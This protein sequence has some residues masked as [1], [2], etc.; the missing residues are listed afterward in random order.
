MPLAS[1]SRLGAYEIIGLIGQ[2]GMGEVYKARDTR[3][4]R[5]VAI[6]ILPDALAADPQFRERFDREARSISQLTHPHICVLYDVGH[7]NGTD[8]LD[9]AHRTGVVHRDLKPGNIMLTK[10]GTKLLD[11]GLAK[12]GLMGSVAPGLSHLP[13]NPPNLT[14]QGTILG[15]FQYMAPEQLEGK[16]VDAR[17]DLFAFGAIVYEMVTGKKAFSGD[18]QASLIGAI[19]HTEPQPMAGGQPLTP[20][21][22]ERLVLACLAKDPDDRWQSARDVVR[23]L[24]HIANASS[25]PSP[26]AVRSR[27]VRPGVVAALVLT[28]GALGI[29]ALLVWWHGSSSADP[30]N[31]VRFTIAAPSVEGRGGFSSS[32]GSAAATQVPPVAIS[33]DGR[34][35]VFGASSSDGRPVLWLRP[36]DRDE[37]RPLPG[38]EGGRYP[39][40]SPDSRTIGLFTQGDLR[41]IAVAGGSPKRIRDIDAGSGGTINSDGTILLVVGVNGGIWRTAVDGQQPTA[42]KLQDTDAAS[43][44]RSPSFLPDGRHFLYWSR[45]QKAIYVASLDTG[46]VE[47]I[48]DSDAAGQYASGRLL[49][50][51]GQT[52]FTQLF[53]VTSFKL[54]GHAQPIAE[55]AITL[56]GYAAVSASNTGTM[57]LASGSRQLSQLTWMDR[58]GNRQGDIGRP[59]SQG[60]ISLGP[61]DQRLLVARV[62]D[63]GS[64]QGIWLFDL[65][66][67]NLDTRIGEGADPVLSRDGAFAF[68]GLPF[69]RGVG[70]IRLGGGSPEVLSDHTGW[71]TDTSLD[72][73]TIL[74]QIPEPGRQFDV[75][76]MNVATKQIK[77]LVATV[78]NE[79]RARYSP[80]E[81]WVAYVSDE[82]KRPEVYVCSVTDSSHRVPISTDGGTQPKWRR[83]GRELYYLAGDRM[84]IMAVEIQVRGK[85]LTAGPPKP[86]FKLNGARTTGTGFFGSDFEPSATGNRFLVNQY[87]TQVGGGLNVIVNWPRTLGE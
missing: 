28:G 61:R 81:H 64:S 34:S 83:D 9:R 66:R 43:D 85:E 19:M 5:T 6:K 77:P 73:R 30:S 74:L 67:N 58:V 42:V 23:E 50:F 80:D 8:F 33:P 72:G 1:G 31:V 22:L 55:V 62:D 56:G 82:S 2:G 20:R 16:D 75:A 76:L 52:L 32:P 21:A 7:H 24:R 26:L 39:F 11:F 86:L 79:G 70:R 44:V 12:T 17:T 71:V 63:D 53:D 48:V 18:S 4:D 78:A 68:Y 45:S 15:T 25:D 49:F 51:R 59:S 87:M 65:A 38:T 46:K 47:R 14:A 3:L 60:A 37:A 36:L 27:V 13:T 10:Q 84:T 41:M 35:I 57:V 29:A 54:S 40:W 69:G